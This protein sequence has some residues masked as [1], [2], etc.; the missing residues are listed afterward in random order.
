MESNTS[1]EIM[2]NADIQRE[3]DAYKERILKKDLGVIVGSKLGMCLKY[4][5]AAKN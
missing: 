3:G 5:I 1:A 2:R 4:D